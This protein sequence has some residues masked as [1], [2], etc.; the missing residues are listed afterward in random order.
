MK[1]SIKYIINK[2]RRLTRRLFQMEQVMRIE[3]TSVAWKAII[4][5]LNYTRI[6]VT[7]KIISQRII[8]M[9]YL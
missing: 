7:R 3:L 6:A 2:K 8:T 9:Q 1:F 4:L 5:P